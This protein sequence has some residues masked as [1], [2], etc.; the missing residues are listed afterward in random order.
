[1]IKRGSGWSCVI[2]YDSELEDFREEKSSRDVIGR[3]GGS[4]L[5]LLAQ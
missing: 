1:M 3:Q 4:L 2:A 5:H